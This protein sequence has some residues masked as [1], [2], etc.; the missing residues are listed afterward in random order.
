MNTKLIMEKGMK[1]ILTKQNGTAKMA[2]NPWRR[3]AWILILLADIGLLA[4]GAMAAL[5]ATAPFLS[6]RRAGQSTG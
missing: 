4:W 5:A 3:I 2:M 1:V 6:A